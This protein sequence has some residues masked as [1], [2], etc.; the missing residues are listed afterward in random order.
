M[1][2]WFPY[3]QVSWRGSCACKGGQQHSLW[4][5]GLWAMYLDIVS[6]M[7]PGAHFSTVCSRDLISCQ[8]TTNTEKAKE[9][10]NQLF[11]WVVVNEIW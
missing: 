10:P 3:P 2:Q 7:D 8:V 11:P 9:K 4:A 5:P 1:L 6:V